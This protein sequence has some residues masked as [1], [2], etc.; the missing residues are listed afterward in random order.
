MGESLKR[1][2]NYPVVSYNDVTTQSSLYVPQTLD[3]KQRDILSPVPNGRGRLPRHIS[4]V[5][6]LEPQRPITKTQ[7]YFINSQTRNIDKNWDSI[8]KSIASLNLE[9]ESWSLR[10]IM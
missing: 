10:K 9:R 7:S 2:T 4:S 3:K 6:A 1:M 5:C 8:N